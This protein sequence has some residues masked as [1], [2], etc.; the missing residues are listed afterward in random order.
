M[1][2]TSCLRDKQLLL[3]NSSLDDFLQH[4][5]FP[6]QFILGVAGNSI[7][8]VV[9]LS[10]GMR[11]KTNSLLSA[12]A[13]A[14]LALLFC[15]LPHSLASFEIAYRSYTFRYF[16]YVSKRQLN[17]FANFFSTAATWLVLTVSVERFI[18]IRSPVHA[19]FKWKEKGVLLIIVPIF[20]GA[21]VITFYHQIAYKYSIHTVC[22]GTQLKGNVRPIDYNW[23]GNKLYGNVL[24]NYI[25][26]GKYLQLITVILVPIVAVAFLN[27]SLICLMRNRMVTRRN[28]NTSDYSMLRNCNDTGIMQRQERKVTVTVLA[29]VTCFTI[30]HAP[31][32][33]PFVWET[34][35]ISKENPLPFLAT[36]SIANSLLI[37]GKVLNFVLFCSSS[38]HFRRRLMHILLPHFMRRSESRKSKKASTSQFKNSTSVP[39]MRKVNTSFSRRSI[40]WQD[41][42]RS[43]FLAEGNN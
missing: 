31:S 17:A 15:M 14:D 37:T 29:I 39:Q 4:Y 36:V 3:T 28:R 2:G 24:T 25:H 1:L 6:I 18:G 11:S 27:V 5:V 10:K 7:N 19:H 33:I 16:Y 8:L 21:F 42:M 34:F 32:L 26:Y 9:L 22:N 30:T 20:I 12:M 40:Q 38:V 35:G 13:F 23:T 41:S 43:K